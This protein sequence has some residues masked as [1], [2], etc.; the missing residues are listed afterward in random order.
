MRI[1]IIGGTRFIGPH[2]V[3]HLVAQG[4]EVT[5]YHRGQ[6]PAPLP[7]A[8]RHLYGERRE[9]PARRAELARLAPEVAVDLFAMTAADA[10][11]AVAGLRG[12]A[13]RLTVISSIDVYRAFGRVIGVEPGPPDPV[14][15][16]EASPLRERRYPYRS[17]P[18]R[19]A[20]DPDRW[21]DDYDKILV[22]QIVMSEPELP[23]TVLRLPMVYGPGDTQHR[24]FLYLKRM[25][26]GRRVIVLD[27][28]TARWRGARGYVENIA[29]AIALAA[30]D[31]RA[32][33]RI[34][35][36]A[37]PETP[38]EADWVRAIGQAAGWDGEVVTVPAD[39]W[40]APGSI[41][42]DLAQ[43][44]S[45]ESS[46]IR[47]ELGYVE[48]VPVDEAL[49]RAVAWERAHPPAR[50]DPARFDYAAEDA[51]LAAR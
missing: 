31:P 21:R 50:Y 43:H 24:L 2:L 14:P 6:T 23:G 5:L 15:L 37:E 16:T 49:R 28:Q 30:T 47:G 4:H 46:R 38:T 41:P 40:R 44:L 29:A 12:I 9:L 35:H 45:V 11:A 51:A 42:G 20:D 48:P 3:R 19:P 10:R 25:D 13:G 22:E 36:V 26:D 34:Y 39:R 32:A 33:G 8:V 7:P 17:A 27:E 18:P 1:L